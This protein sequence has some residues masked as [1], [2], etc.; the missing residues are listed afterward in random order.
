MKMSKYLMSDIH[1]DKDTFEKMLEKLGYDDSSD[2]LIINGDV[3]DRGE[4]GVELLLKVM[5][6][7]KNDKAIMLKGNH[8]L[9]ISL[10]QEMILNLLKGPLEKI[11]R[12]L[13][14]IILLF[15]L[16]NIDL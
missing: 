10:K 4:H 8:E 14:C 5:E 11:Q 13:F 1:G 12:F 3:L 15:Q 6:L 9:F 7:V 2:F 16:Y